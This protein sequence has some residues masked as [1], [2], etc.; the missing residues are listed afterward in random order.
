MLPLAKVLLY[1][2]RTTKPHFREFGNDSIT[3]DTRLRQP[4]LAIRAVCAA[5]LVLVI[6]AF[7][8]D[9]STAGAQHIRARSAILVDMASGEVLFEEN[10]SE[11]IAP[12]SITKVLTLYLAFEAIEE[13]RVH[14]TDGVHIS[15]N[16]VSARPVRMGLKAGTV[17]SLQELIYG[18][19]IISGNDAAIAVAEHVG[20]SEENFV[21]MMNIK[22]KQLGMWSSNFVNPNG[23]PAAGQ[24]TTARD[25]VKLS[26]AY[27]SRFPQ[28]LEIHSQQKFTYNNRTRSNANRLLGSCPGVDGLKTGFV[29]ASGYNLAA[30]GMRGGRRLVAVVLG[31]TSP[32]L[33]KMEATRLL[34]Y[35]F[36]GTPLAAVTMAH[37]NA[38]QPGKRS[39]MAGEAPL[40]SK[41]VNACVVKNNKTVVLTKTRQKA[42]IVG[43]SSGTVSVVQKGGQTKVLKTTAVT[44]S[45]A[46]KMSGA[47]QGVSKASPIDSS[48]RN[49]G[50]SVQTKTIQTAAKRSA[51]ND[52]EKKNPEVETTKEKSSQKVNLLGKIQIQTS[53]KSKTA[54]QCSI[55]KPVHMAN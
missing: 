49:P 38:Q 6:T 45:K 4:R 26:V 28:C 46:S 40:R 14:L 30:T 18:T 22:A 7:C 47:K 32:G 41:A 2:C 10:A 33:R 27:L 9:V 24:V 52:S 53:E 20:G 21:R 42:R 11:L 39:K 1:S 5:A 34:E 23:L 43:Q 44:N 55:K 36:E 37:I 3:T 13:G 17:V 50:K 8:V 25:I 16:A 19:A 54:A 31:A 35:G 15:Q 29:N 51:I 12:A 48:A